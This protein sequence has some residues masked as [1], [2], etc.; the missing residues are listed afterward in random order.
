MLV[1]RRRV[2]HH[3]EQTGQVT[4]IDAREIDGSPTY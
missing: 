3:Q 1:I 2:N 4:E